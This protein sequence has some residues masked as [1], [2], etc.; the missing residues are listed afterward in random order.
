LNEDLS[1]VITIQVLPGMQGHSFQYPLIQSIQDEQASTGHQPD[2]KNS[3][4]RY[5]I[6]PN[7]SH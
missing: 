1:Q 5:Y 3:I 2:S 7:N 4:N 6:T